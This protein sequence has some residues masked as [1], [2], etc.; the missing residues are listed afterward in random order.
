MNIAMLVLSAALAASGTPAA[1][2]GPNLGRGK[3]LFESRSLGTSGKRC[4][5]CH[6]GGRRFEEV[7][8]TP[9]PE[10]AAYVNSCIVGMLAGKALP[11][12]ADDLRSLVLYVRSLAPRHR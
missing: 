7:A 9:D 10:L 5:D 12:G 8:E 1:S 2:P 3:A 11:A 4:A 6:H